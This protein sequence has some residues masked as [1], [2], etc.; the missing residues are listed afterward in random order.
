MNKASELVSIQ[1]R[2]NDDCKVDDTCANSKTGYHNLHPSC[3]VSHNVKWSIL[4]DISC[5]P[6]KSLAKDIIL[7]E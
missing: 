4:N 3:T 7:V 1:S 2:S 5:F 6:P